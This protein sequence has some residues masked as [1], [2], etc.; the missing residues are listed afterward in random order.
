MDLRLRQLIMREPGIYFLVTDNSTLQTVE[1]DPKLRLYFINSAKG[2]VNSVVQFAKGDISGFNT[3]FGKSTR[4]M[5]KKGNFSHRVCEKS[6]TSGPIAVVNLRTFDDLVDKTQITSINPNKELVSNTTK[7]VPYSSLYKRNG[8][9]TLNQNLVT[10]NNYETDGYLNFANVGTSALSII[11][12]KSTLDEVKTLTNEGDKTLVETEISID[13]YPGL[14]TDQYLK[15][16]FVT[17]YVFNTSFATNPAGNPY[18]G[19]LFDV[20]GNITL[21]NLSELSNIRESGFYRKYIGSVIPGLISENNLP[22]SIDDI[23]FQD[24]MISGVMSDINADLLETELDDTDV[25]GYVDLFGANTIAD[26]LGETIPGLLSYNPLLIT[27]Y[28]TVIQTVKFPATIASENVGPTL[29]DKTV[30]SKYQINKIDSV[31]FETSREGGIRIGDYLLGEK[32]IVQV[33]NIE[34]LET[35]DVT[36]DDPELPFSYDLVKVTATGPISYEVTGVDPNQTTLITKF[37][38]T[39]YNPSFKVKPVLLESYTPRDDQFLNGTSTRQEE[40]LNLMI[41]PSI[42]KGCKSLRGLRYVIDCFKS[43]IQPDYKWQFGTLAETLD[44]NNKFIRVIINEPFIND[45]FKS[46]NPLLKDT[47]TGPLDYKYLPE[48]GNKQY[49]TI[50]L[51]KFKTG[52]D[53]CFFFGPGDIV[54]SVIGP[55]TGQISNKFYEKR[56]DF[57][58]VAN[59]TGYLQGVTQLEE[60]F[61]DTDR[62]YLGQFNYNPVI[63][64]NGITI[65]GNMTGQK[66][67]S[68]QQQIQNS[69]LLCYIKNTLYSMAKTDVFTK[70]SYNEYLRTQ[71]E[72]QTFM[73]NLYLAGAIKSGPKVICDLGNNTDEIADY[74]IKLVRVE[75][76][77]LNAIEKVVFDLNIF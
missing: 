35:I 51:S 64:W 56:F 77:P 49:S 7:S 66:T 14:N 24:A 13:D 11:A 31:T 40:I 17:V 25:N 29:T 33:K 52:A 53:K 48:G 2:P 50:L 16:T 72:T 5:E 54:K 69:E 12:V 59:T 1:E 55:L 46:T 74:K 71:T 39:V 4:T 62:K 37:Y 61:D 34:L 63:D 18:Y 58:I 68:K 30:V 6:L 42:V 27:D 8:F 9:W 70:G 20:S 38:P 75:Y 28:E 41:S 67:I 15:D 23:M 65:F 45:M 10:E 32:G 36:P 22:M 21:G 57:D 26:E 3:V 44:E 19:H 47:P 60:V 76:T 43:F 73:D